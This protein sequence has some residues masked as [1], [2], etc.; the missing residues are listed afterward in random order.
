[1]NQD[2]GTVQR[3][4]R[5]ILPSGLF[6]Q[7]EAESREWIMTCSQ[8]GAEQSLWDTGGARWKATGNPTVRARC[9]SCGQ[10]TAHK[11]L[12]QASHGP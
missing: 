5:A 3:L 9:T 7:I 11:L 2:L 10:V 12:R 8:C 1:M 4:L 6:R